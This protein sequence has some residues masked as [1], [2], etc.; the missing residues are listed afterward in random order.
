MVPWFLLEKHT[1]EKQTWG[2][3]MQ[4]SHSLALWFSLFC[5]PKES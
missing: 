3:L 5:F 1:L 4:P 2:V